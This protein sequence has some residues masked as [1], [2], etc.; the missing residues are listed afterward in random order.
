[1]P[2]QP[3][4]L[5]LWWSRIANLQATQMDIQKCICEEHPPRN[6]PK[7]S[8][9]DVH[10]DFIVSWTF[11]SFPVHGKNCA[12]SV[13]N[14]VSAWAVPSL[15]VDWKFGGITH[16][17]CQ[18]IG[19]LFLWISFASSDAMPYVMKRQHDNSFSICVDFGVLIWGSLSIVSPSFFAF[20]I[21]W[22]LSWLFVRRHSRLTFW[23]F[24][25]LLLADSRC[26]WVSRT[27]VFRIHSCFNHGLHLGS[28]VPRRS[29]PAMHPSMKMSSM[30]FAVSAP[31]ASR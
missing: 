4:K 22:W 31:L 30:R 21:C 25:V 11:R 19:W 3:E 16:C 13:Q 28:T 24:S 29:A 27:W 8:A 5:L 20:V 7:V 10:L 17:R 23:Y 15:K 9:H 2:K 1:M 6:S 18:K 12:R 14:L 26:F